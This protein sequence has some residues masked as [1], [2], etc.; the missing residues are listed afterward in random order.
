MH[1]SSE[2]SS[3]VKIC[4]HR[5]SN[6]I[7]GSCVEIECEGKRIIIDMGTP[8]DAD[9]ET[10]SLVPDIK[11]LKEG[12]SSILGV[13]VS[14][15]HKDHYGLIKFASP[16]IPVYIGEKA[17]KI[18]ET[19]S[20]FVPNAAV[21][22]PN[23]H[24]YEDKKPFIIGYTSKGEIKIT[25]FLVDHSAFDSYALLVEIAGKKILYSGDFRC[26]GRKGIL[27]KILPKNTL[28]KN[29]DLVLLEGSSFGRLDKDL[30]FPK[31]DELENTFA[32]EFRKTKGLALVHCSSQNIDRITSIYHACKKSGRKLVVDLYQASVLRTCYNMSRP[33]FP[34]AVLYVPNKQRG[35]VVK[36]NL[37]GM[38]HEYSKPRIY[39]EEIAKSPEKYTILFREIHI[40]DFVKFSELFENAR[41]F[42]SMWNGYWKEDSDYYKKAR[43][44]VEKYNLEKI[45]I[46]TSGHA[47]VKDLKSFVDK[48]NSPKIVPIHT[49]YPQSYSEIF[50]NVEI[51]QDGEWFT[52]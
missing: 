10:Q 12:D 2:A 33:L 40:A 13:I 49:F 14:H 32:E 52:V 48:L 25:P 36:K 22:I 35:T 46:H 9:E 51:H 20:I 42:Y 4:I 21:E 1:Q 26:H 50:K 8:L 17:Y 19:T 6:Q 31:E 37:F 30:Q 23:K 38:M 11:G 29:L 5:G 15:P 18:I 7:G 43:E 44:F 27:S 3:E 45:D 41:F 16:E 34:E 39:I 28:L 24:F 47:S